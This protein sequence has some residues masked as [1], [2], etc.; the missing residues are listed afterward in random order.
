[1]TDRITEL[2]TQLAFQDSTIHSLNEVVTDQQNQI[3]LL[4]EQLKQIKQ[5]MQSL[6]ETVHR[7]EADEPP[8]P[9]Y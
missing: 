4:R 6:A 8:P 1:M 2:E 7:P 3:D 5:Q 9:H